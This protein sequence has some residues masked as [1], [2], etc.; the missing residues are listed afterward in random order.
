MDDPKA[1][2]LFKEVLKKTFAKKLAW[3]AT[4]DEDTFVA[5]IGNYTLAL[6]SYTSLGSWG[7]REGPPVV[8]LKDDGQNTLIEINSGIGGVTADELKSLLVF[9]RRIALKADEKIDELLQELKRDE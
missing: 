5:S 6:T 9:A 8:T 2:A 1:L 3:Q 7:E 4:A